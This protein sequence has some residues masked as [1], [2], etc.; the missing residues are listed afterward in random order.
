MEEIWKDIKGYEGYYK[1]SNTGKVKG[2]LLYNRHK[3]M[4]VSRETI[5]K[6]DITQKGYARVTLCK[7]AEHKRYNVHRLVASHFILN[8]DNKPQ[9][10]HING[11]KTDNRVENLEWCTNGE[12]E[13]HAYELGLKKKKYGGDNPMKKEITATNIITGESR[14][15]NSIIDASKILQI[16]YNTIIY[17]LQGKTKKP[18]KFYFKYKEV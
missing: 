3:K 6:P 1:I 8:L 11:I 7:N 4:Y 15:F 13:K 14:D 9:V 10:N 17:I 5:L 12:N 18:T 2:L 16:G